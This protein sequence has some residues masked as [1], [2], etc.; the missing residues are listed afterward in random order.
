MKIKYSTIGYVATALLAAYVSYDLANEVGA[1]YHIGTLAEAS[2]GVA[3]FACLTGAMW[4]TIAQ[5]AASLAR[6]RRN[7][8]VASVAKVLAFLAGYGCI[9]LLAWGVSTGS[10]SSWQSAIELTGAVFG[11]GVFVCISLLAEPQKAEEAGAV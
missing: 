9:W 3:F 1:T 5:V 4:T 6:E 10:N 7:G 2:G 8:W 11:I